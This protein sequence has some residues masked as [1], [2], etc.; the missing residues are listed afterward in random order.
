MSKTTVNKQCSFPDGEYKAIGLCLF[1]SMFSTINLFILVYYHKPLFYPWISPISPKMTTLWLLVY[2]SFFSPKVTLR[3]YV[4]QGGRWDYI[5]TP[6][7]DQM[8]L[9]V[10]NSPCAMRLSSS[11]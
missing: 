7:E 4:I 1:A 3:D 8:A 10:K 2:Y 11:D 6:F 5:A 9:R